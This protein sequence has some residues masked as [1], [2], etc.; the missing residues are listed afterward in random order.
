TG[1]TNNPLNKMKKM[2]S[3]RKNEITKTS[4]N[5]LDV[6]G[7]QNSIIYRRFSTKFTNKEAQKI[8]EMNKLNKPKKRKKNKQ[9]K[10]SSVFGQKLPQSFSDL[11]ECVIQAMTY[12]Q[13]Y[14]SFFFSSF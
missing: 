5:L 8:R 7:R 13:K 10:T 1:E 11:P 2:Y 12:I 4:K 3:Q 9:Q 6:V 14:G